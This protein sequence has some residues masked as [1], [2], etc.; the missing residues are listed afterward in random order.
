MKSMLL[1]SWMIKFGCAPR[2]RRATALRYEAID[3]GVD[4]FSSLIICT[5]SDGLSPNTTLP[6]GNLKTNFAVLAKLGCVRM[7]VMLATLTPDLSLSRT[8]PTPGFVGRFGMQV[9]VFSTLGDRGTRR[10]LL[11]VLVDLYTL[12]VSVPRVGT[13]VV[14]D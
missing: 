14:D 4:I 9:I 7:L 10:T 3:R 12:G 8:P 5:T 6:S 13:G 11:V 2:M 1:L